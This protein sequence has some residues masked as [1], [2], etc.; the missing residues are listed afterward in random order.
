[1]NKTIDN[2]ITNT[3]KKV[4]VDNNKQYLHWEQIDFLVRLELPHYEPLK[5][6]SAT[7]LRIDYIK[8][9][10]ADRQWTSQYGVIISVNR[11]GYKLSTNPQEIKGAIDERYG[12]AMSILTGS[13]D[14]KEAHTVFHNKEKYS[15]II[16]QDGHHSAGEVKASW[17]Q[18][19]Y[20]EIKNG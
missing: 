8:G 14:L 11:V 9:V 16:P 4:M 1:M 20:K 2:T 18:D 6:T 13:N 19:V 10:N 17:L 5:N 15:E 3:L 12:R 7:K